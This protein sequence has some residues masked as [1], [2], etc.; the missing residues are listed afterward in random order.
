MLML[1]LALVLLI[2]GAVWCIY[3]SD[4]CLFCVNDK[5]ADKDIY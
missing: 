4:V 5:L 3:D 2:D 1:A